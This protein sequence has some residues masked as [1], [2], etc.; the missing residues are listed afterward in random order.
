MAMMYSG[1]T[2]VIEQKR[3]RRKEVASEEGGESGEESISVKISGHPC[4]MLM[5]SLVRYG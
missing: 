4:Q 2:L 5:R 1:N 3:M